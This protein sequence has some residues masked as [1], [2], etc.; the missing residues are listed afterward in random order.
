M[1][2]DGGG[3]V[4]RLSKPSGVRMTTSAGLSVNLPAPANNRTTSVSLSSDAQQV[5]ELRQA[6][7]QAPSLQ[8]GRIEALRKQV[9]DGSYQV[10]SSKLARVMERV[11]S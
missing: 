1:R 8:A 5:Q 9:Q 2:I 4:E 10:E 6:V 3:E 11:L 7:D